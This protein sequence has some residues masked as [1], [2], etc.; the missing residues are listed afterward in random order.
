VYFHVVSRVGAD[1]RKLLRTSIFI[2]IA[3]VI[4]SVTNAAQGTERPLTVDDI[5]KLSDVGRAAVRPGTDMFVWEQTP[6][7]DT[8][9]DY[10]AG[11]TGT[12]QGSDYAVFTV[13]GK[14]E[15]PVKL[16]EPPARTTYRL[17][18]FSKDG[19]FLSMLA[20][21]D[22]AVRLAAFDF[23][24]HQLKEYP[25][26]PFFPGVQPDPDWAWIDNHRLAVAAYPP[27]G[28]PWHLTFRRGIAARLNTGWQKSWEGKEA[29]V[30]QYDS[31]STDTN[32]ALPGRLLLVDIA[33]GDIQQLG[34]G[35]FSG[36]RPSPDGRWLAAVEQSML[37]QYTLDHPNVDWR[38]A[39][40]ILTVIP[41]T[42]QSATREVSP[43]LD[44]LPD[45]M[46]WSPSSK[47][48]AFFASNYGSELES[49][50]FWILDASRSMPAV[51]SHAGLSLA[52]QRARGGAGWPER[53]VWMADSLAVF[54][55]STPGKP[56]TF[57]SEDIKR[58]GVI[59]PRVKVS[60]IVP[61]WFLLSADSPARDLTPEMKEVSPFPIISTASQLVIVGDGRAWRLNESDS[62]TPL[63]PEFSQL[64]GGL[65]RR[66][67]FESRADG[68]GAIF[69]IEGSPMLLA[70]VGVQ[71][72]SQTLKL[73]TTPPRTSVLA[74]SSS[75]RILAQIGVG[76]GAQLAVL[77]A[78]TPPEMLGEINAV[79]DRVLETHWIDFNYANFESAARPQ[80]Y[81]CLLL[82]PD[83]QPGHKYPLVVDV[84]P[85]TTGG[86]AA[87]DVQ[88][89]FAMGAH[90][91]PYSEHLL[92]AR[93]F[94]V[95]RPDTAGDVSRTE[96]GPQ[97]AVSA[98]VGRGVDAVLAA[99]YGDPARVGIFGVSQGGFLSLWLAT[100]NHRF[101]AVVSLN[102]WSDLV[103]HFF[104]MNWSQELA[105]SEVPTLGDSSRYLAPAGSEFSMGGTPWQVPQRYIQNSP[106]WRSDAVTAPVL[107]IHSDMDEFEDEQYKAFFSSLF[108]QK[109]D[110][111]LLIYR[112]EG[113]MP[114]SPANIRDMWKNILFWFDRY[115]NVKRDAQGHMLFGGEEPDS[116][117][118]FH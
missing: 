115:L 103:S 15:K 7:Y 65:A 30:D 67:L 29:S 100:Q 104:G 48:L 6:P 75:G 20:M 2:G 118:T 96:I 83:Y 116:Q 39:R 13:G 40:S 76:K 97:A 99:G 113:H 79:L 37:P 95:F 55:H 80:L 25:I 50:N 4:S 86:C 60:S 14:S 109:K 35:Q 69:T 107:L 102:G 34:S 89:Q 114:S 18:N 41:L 91:A 82:P 21:R 3:M 45:S 101:K 88:Q 92:A 42:G 27:G 63:F 44:V 32:K 24:R 62:P 11:T 70:H 53:A 12:W 81:G 66:T 74:Q 73:L 33:S 87:P 8:L 28:A 46:L 56:G 94:I 72:E 43:Q 58:T 26:A 84:Y 117:P 51:V 112:G 38:Y 16:F 111:R 106:L 85:G 47:R 61:H 23:Q 98:I 22:G 36:L 5:L 17:G 108:I 77:R 49:G 31:Y 59:D 68:G 110:A 105:P 90:P 71:N 1:P 52:S 64:L 19:R 54:A 10:G 9:A 78:Q 57:A 93:G